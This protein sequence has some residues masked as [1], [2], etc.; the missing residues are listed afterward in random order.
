M[1]TRDKSSYFNR[2]ESLTISFL[3]VKN[4]I[5]IGYIVKDYVIN[6]LNN[7]EIYEIKVQKNYYRGKQGIFLRMILLLLMR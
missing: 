1:N 4:D 7:N 5:G 2:I 3:F 6:G